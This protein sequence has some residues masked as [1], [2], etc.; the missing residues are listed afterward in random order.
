LRVAVGQRKVPADVAFGGAFYA[1]VDSEAAG[2]PIDVE[3]LPELRRTGIAITRAI[4][5]SQTIAHPLDTT[6]SGLAG[7]IFTA[8]PSDDGSALRNIA[9]FSGADAERSPG[10]TGTAALLAVVDAMGLVDHDTPFVHE[11]LIGTRLSGRIVARTTV[12]EYPAIVA[13]IEGTAWVTGEHT[14]FIDDEDPLNDG[15]RI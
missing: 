7:T 10:G 11:G 12:G 1:I 15:V 9:I 3:H 6:L 5:A 4:E 8:P 2:L 13:E 14:F